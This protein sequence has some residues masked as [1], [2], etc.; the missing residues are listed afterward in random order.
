MN[1]KVV[2]I[3]GLRAIYGN[4]GNAINRHSTRT[5]TILVN[6]KDIGL[7]IHIDRILDMIPVGFTV[8]D[9]GYSSNK[10]ISKSENTNCK[11]WF[12]IEQKLSDIISS[13][14]DSPIKEGEQVELD[15]SSPYLDYFHLY[16]KEVADSIQF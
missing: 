9:F 7:G 3:K 14:N 16:G 15:R 1:T 6:D 13:I 4:D 5:Y 10:G 11:T 12:Q 2:E 8:Y